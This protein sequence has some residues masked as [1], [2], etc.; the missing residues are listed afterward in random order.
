MVEY[1]MG[2]EQQNQT[3]GLGQAGRR[4]RR[5]LCVVTGFISRPPPLDGFCAWWFRDGGERATCCSLQAKL[6]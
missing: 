5:R 3:A 2:K 4:C 6:R 1:E